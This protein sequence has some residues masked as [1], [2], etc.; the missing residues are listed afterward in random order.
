MSA[1]LSQVGRTLPCFVEVNISGEPSKQGLEMA[2]WESD[3]TQR[4]ILRKY[5]QTIFDLPGLAAIGLMT[6]AP[7]NANASL[8]RSVFRRT[9]E[10]AQWL[11]TEFP[12]SAQ[13]ML[14]MG[15]SDDFEV[16]IEEGATHIRVGRALFGERGT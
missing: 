10:M 3:A 9:R 13:L 5:F 2:N 15:M 1:E 12:D 8:V 14:S 11:R 7:W 4:A 6:M 16:A